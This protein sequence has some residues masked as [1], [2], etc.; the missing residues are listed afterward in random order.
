[1]AAR[2]CS[3]GQAAEICASVCVRVCV[4]ICECACVFVPACV[5]CAGCAARD[6]PQGGVGM[7]AVLPR[8]APWAAIRVYMG[9]TPAV[10]SAWP[11]RGGP[12]APAF[13]AAH[14]Q[15]PPSQPC[16]AC[17][18][19]QPGAGQVPYPAGSHC[20]CRLCPQPWV[21]PEPWQPVGTAAQRRQ[22]VPFQRLSVVT[23]KDADGSPV[24]ANSLGQGWPC[25]QGLRAPSSLPLGSQELC[26]S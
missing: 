7:Q 8:R 5:C 18:V 16:L 24:G 23:G 1:M 3:T 13:T 20:E 12:S 2:L 17:P 21:Q 11:C 9:V 10:G 19:P 4:Y 26:G 15:L 22:A 6:V 14:G 25:S